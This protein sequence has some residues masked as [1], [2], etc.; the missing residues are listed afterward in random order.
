MASQAM[1]GKSRRYGVST[2]VAV[3]EAHGLDARQ[4]PSTAC[5]CSL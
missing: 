3:E 4:A 5:H 2:S 1:P